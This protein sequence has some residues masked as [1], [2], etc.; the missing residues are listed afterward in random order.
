M[1]RGVFNN[2][3]AFIMCCKI[4]RAISR[5]RGGVDTGRKGRKDFFV[6]IDNN[7]GL[8]INFQASRLEV[9]SNLKI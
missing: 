8:F 7:P 5:G 3:L 6:V 1:N 4:S 9:L 2:I